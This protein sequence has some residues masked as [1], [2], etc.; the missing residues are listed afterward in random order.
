MSDDKK[1][2]LCTG[3]VRNNYNHYIINPIIKLFANFY[4]NDEYLL[5]E[6]QNAATSQSFYSPIFFIGPFSWYL[7]FCP[8]KTLPQNN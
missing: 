7:Q 8:R 3:Y 4:T 6:I 1:Y 5:N 2:L